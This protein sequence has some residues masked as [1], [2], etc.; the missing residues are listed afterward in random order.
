MVPADGCREDFVYRVG[1]LLVEA[2]NLLPCFVGGS[3]AGAEIWAAALN[4]AWCLDNTTA[5]MGI[6]VSPFSVGAAVTCAVVF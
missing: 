4:L 6:G 1:V 2:N 3:E 5:Y